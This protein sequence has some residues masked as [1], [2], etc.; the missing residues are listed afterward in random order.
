MAVTRAAQ[1]QKRS[2][3]KLP[4]S[5]IEGVPSHTSVVMSAQLSEVGSMCHDHGALMPGSPRTMSPFGIVPSVPPASNASACATFSSPTSS[6][7]NVSPTTSKT[8]IG[9]PEIEGAADGGNAVDGGGV[10]GGSGAQ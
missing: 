9:F 3:V 2:N 1:G 5:I 7:R 6:I 4:S 8:A 10:P